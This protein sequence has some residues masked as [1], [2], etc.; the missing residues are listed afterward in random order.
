M[1]QVFRVPVN[2]HVGKSLLSAARQYETMLEV[3]LEGVQNSLDA[4]AGRIWI[5]LN[6]KV[7][8]MRIADDGKGVTRQEMNERLQNFFNSAK[9]R[10]KLGTFGLGFISPL[11]KCPH[12]SFTSCSESEATG[13]HEWHFDS[14]EITSRQQDVEVT[15]R[16]L[17]QLRFSND[18]PDSHPTLRK[19]RSELVVSK[20]TPD[21]S[22]ARV[23][24]NELVSKIRGRYGAAMR[25]YKSQI[26]LRITDESGRVTSQVIA[27]PEFEGEPLPKVTLSDARV[28]A[29]TFR[30]YLAPQ[31]PKVK[32]KKFDEPEQLGVV[33]REEGRPFRLDF[34]TF[35]TTHVDKVGSEVAT[36]LKS[37]VFEGEI[38][39]EPKLLLREDRRGFLKH[40]ALDGL[41][42]VLSR[43]FDEH[44]Q[45][46]LQ[47]ASASSE[48]EQNQQLCRFAERAFRQLL[49]LT[50]FSDIQEIIRQIGLSTAGSGHKR[51]Q[52]IGMLD[53][54]SLSDAVGRTGE[55]E[56][57][58]GD[59]AKAAPESER[60]DMIHLL[61]AG[62]AGQIR[63]IVKRG[64]Q[65][66]IF[67]ADPMTW[68]PR[69]D[70]L[71]DFDLENGILFFNSRH[72]DWVAC[73]ESRY[74]ERLVTHLTNFVA[75]NV[76]RLFGERERQHFHEKLEFFDHTLQTYCFI[77]LH[78]EQFAKL[79]FAP[80]ALVPRKPRHSKS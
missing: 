76:I 51:R 53:F 29:V 49:K 60:A 41:C 46:L 63:R 21:K 73:R 32:K 43:W 27:P 47:D 62:P 68:S 38:L 17:P 26:S 75:I 7:R 52:V 18:A 34:S 80:P 70:K 12:F 67:D 19:W 56:G 65:S 24:A 6:Q 74:A 33:L 23:T 30:L 15:C 79:S 58:S 1:A 2:V 72:P 20:Y 57:G 22:V 48:R 28:G 13:Y 36:A 45:A 31:K 14:E 11:G 10:D 61:A 25:R 55:G 69:R 40:E 54:R 35:A 9:E 78:G 50:V 44:G 59:T 42:A 3:I 77:L 64:S 37:G 8:W 4:A 71:W 16:P 39:H 5:H 66:L